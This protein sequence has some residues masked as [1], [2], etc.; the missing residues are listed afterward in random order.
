[1]PGD[2]GYRRLIGRAAEVAALDSVLDDSRAPAL[3][4]IVGEPGIGKSRLLAELCERA[5]SR[6]A[7]VVE[8]RATE[9]QRETPF[10]VF[11]DALDDYLGSLNP[12]AFEALVP[13]DGAELARIFPVLAGLGGE[14]IPPLGDERYRSHRAV[15]ALMEALA[16]TRPLIVALDDMH[17]ADQASIELLSHLIRRPPRAGVLMALAYRD[18]HANAALRAALSAAD[19]ERSL[20]L[21]LG[22]LRLAD[23]TEL[24][25]PRVDPAIVPELF[26]ESGGNPLYLDRLARAVR[27]GTR[28]GRGRGAHVIAGTTQSVPDAVA[29][30]VAV[31]VDGLAPD[32]AGL[33]RAAAVAGETFEPDL[34]AAVSELDE[35]T[36]LNLLDELLERDL[37]RTT[38]VP[39]RF[40]FRH[41]IVRRA[42]YE[43]AKPGWLLAA[44]GRAAAELAARGAPPLARAA[45]VERS[46]R[47]GNDAAVALLADAG[48]AAAARAPAAAAHWFEAA[49]RLLSEDDV[50]RRLGLLI[51]RAQALGAAGRFGDARAILDEV[52]QLLPAD[53]HAVRAEVVASCARIDQILGRHG[54]ARE[55]LTSA[56]EAL[57]GRSEQ[58][59]DL[60]IQLAAECFFTADFAGLERWVEEA[61]ADAAS[62]DVAA[63]RA[64]ATGLLG[65]AAYMTDDAGAARESLDRA[66]ALFEDLDDEQLSRRLHSLAWCGICEVYLERFDRALGLF[67]RG[68]EV[69][70]ATGHGHIPTLMRIGQGL[71]LLWQGR[72]DEGGARVELAVD[73]SLLT[74]NRQFLTW[75]RWVG[76]WGAILAGELG[77]AVRIGEEAVAEAGELRDPVS[78]LAG[79][80]LAEARLES[81]D[82]EGSRE[83][84]LAA[85]GGPELPLIERGFKSRWYEILAR[86]AL[87]VGDLRG[88]EEWAGRAWAAADGLEIPGRVSEA[89]RARAE[90]ALAQDDPGSAVEASARAVE[91]ATAAGTPIEAARARVLAGRALAAAGDPDGGASE[92]ERARGELDRLGARALSRP[93]GDGAA[94]ARS[95]CGPPWARGPRRRGDRGA[96]R[97]GAGGRGAGRGG[98]DE[99][100]DRRGAVPEPED[101]GEPHGA[102]I[103]QARDLLPHAGGDAAR[104][105]ARPR[106]GFMWRCPRDPTAT[107]SPAVRAAATRAFRRFATRS[108]RASPCRATGSRRCS[109]TRS[110]TGG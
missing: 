69:A 17:W 34:A 71:A 33:L 1:M 59:T 15:R 56:L 61:L 73:A 10:A 44:H 48:E 36:A 3:V 19:P 74:A 96:Q 40:R 54:E 98:K 84:L 86:A 38:E 108:R 82:P 57:P 21:E 35:T 39:R 58:A 106:I 64:A 24:L 70:L 50:G 103:R 78:A 20:R 95:P 42:V 5:D 51:A 68:I 90:V 76:C 8:G 37:I 92:L 75:A 87:A 62:Q 52:L 79:C 32:V 27:T 46:A 12:R 16:G 89:W 105:R 109:T 4:E 55:L 9:L 31:E 88:A 49:L 6:K 104:R 25:G 22:P 65:C 93:G 43:S 11:V 7:L 28:S 18:P 110:P 99:P 91:A 26:R 80:Y 77:A 107:T 72:L 97:S 102:D 85:A 53:R 63:A 94:Q 29:D 14:A 30:S 41:P 23:A 100:R 47:P 60:K 101:G 2:D 83:E 45:H 81:G 67:D 13:S 66:A